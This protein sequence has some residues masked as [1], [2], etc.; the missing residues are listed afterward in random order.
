[1]SHS[2]LYIHIPAHL[3]PSR[4]PFLLNRRLQP[5][6]ACQDISLEKL[7]FDL[8][9]DCATQLRA[10]GLTTTLHA[11]YS[12]FSPGS[13]RKSVRKRSH[14]LADKSLLLAEK[15]RARRII[16]HPGLAHGC[17]HLKQRHWLDRCTDFWPEFIERA[18]AI[19]CVICIE[20]IFSA[21]PDLI[22]SL[23]ER[24][25]SPHIGHV[26]DIGHWNIFGAITL[27]DWLERTAPH[28]AHLHLH[29]NHGE[30][31]EHKALGQGNIPFK[32]LFSWLR[33]N[34]GRRT[35]TLENH[36]LPC[37]ETSLKVVSELFPAIH[38]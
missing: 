10:E 17:G 28:L 35:M 6:V 14:D 36:N 37:T 12:G 8:L 31:D 5:E 33:G 20:N 30:R 34:R 32:E 19:D 27:N 7:N 15:L 25:D 38:I 4:L 11:P 24:I 1:M 22:V 2:P 16:F 26:F 9:G 18:E 21:T 13:G 3:L 23:L 29:D